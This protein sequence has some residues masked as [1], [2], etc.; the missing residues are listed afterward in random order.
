MQSTM[1]GIDE[2][3]K[4]NLIVKSIGIPLGISKKKSTPGRTEIEPVHG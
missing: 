3:S 1:L 4:C 2:F